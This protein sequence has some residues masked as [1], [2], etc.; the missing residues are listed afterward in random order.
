MEAEIN[1]KLGNG[2]LTQ[3]HAEAEKHW[4]EQIQGPK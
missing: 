3:L 4:R 1:R 2:I